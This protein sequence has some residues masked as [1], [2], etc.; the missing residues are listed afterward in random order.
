MDSLNCEM[1]G[2]VTVSD[3]TNTI[4]SCGDKERP[5]SSNGGV[6]RRRDQRKTPSGRHTVKELLS[7]AKD[8]E[9]QRKDALKRT[10]YASTAATVASRNKKNSSNMSTSNTEQNL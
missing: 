2:T 1:I 5:K 4:E 6:R 3:N 10:K 8:K 9:E 7:Q